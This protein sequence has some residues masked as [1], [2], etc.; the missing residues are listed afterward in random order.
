MG[1]LITLLLGVVLLLFWLDGRVFQDELDRWDR[2][3]DLR[4]EERKKR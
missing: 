4:R 1:A 2:E 3:Y